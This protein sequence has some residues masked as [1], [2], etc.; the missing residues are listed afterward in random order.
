MEITLKKIIGRNMFPVLHVEF[1][2]LYASPNSS[3][4][5]MSRRMAWAGYIEIKIV[6]RFPVRKGQEK[7][8]FER[9]RCR[10]EGNIKIALI[11]MRCVMD[12]SGCVADPTSYP[13]VT[14]GFFP[15]G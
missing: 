1:Y 7:R 8:S 6:Y 15:P 4:V 10:W 3:W 2:N 9:F 11:E 14:T 5:V 13:V 12:S